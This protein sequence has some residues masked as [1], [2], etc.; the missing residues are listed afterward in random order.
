MIAGAS[1]SRNSR[2]GASRR[3]QSFSHPLL[4]GLCS[5]LR[6]NARLS[7]G[8]EGSQS[9]QASIVLFARLIKRLVADA[10]ETDFRGPR[11]HERAAAAVAIDTLQRQALEHGLAAARA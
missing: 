10:I 6:Y 4:C 11:Q 1:W 9:R 8:L 3:C 7:A 2:A 5:G